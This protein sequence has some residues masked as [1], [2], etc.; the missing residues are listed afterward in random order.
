MERSTGR[1][2][3]LRSV[4]IGILGFGKMPADCARVLVDNGA[5]ISFIYETEER[6]FSPL[7]SF[8]EKQ[9]IPF[10]RAGPAETTSLL[11]AVGPPTVVFSINNNYIFP[12]DLIRNGRLRIINFHN[13]FLPSYRGHGRVVPTWVIFNGEKRTGAT[14]HMVDERIDNGRILDQE[15]FGLGGEDTALDVSMRC[16]ESG[17]AMFKRCWEKFLDPSY[18]GEPADGP[19]GPVYSSPDRDRVYRRADIPNGGRLDSAWDL[20]TSARFLRS[21]DYSPFRLLVPPLIKVGGEEFLVT[22]YKVS[23]GGSEDAGDMPDRLG[24]AG[25]GTVAHVLRFN[26]GFIRLTLSK[27]KNGQDT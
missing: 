3:Q 18:A 2:C 19:L 27:R 1:H 10:L 4:E 26:D 8:C 7:R 13:S 11:A 20:E 25:Q 15:A 21:L 14:W 17:I 5:R 16:I 12:R 23:R 9:G 6:S 22:G 24:Q